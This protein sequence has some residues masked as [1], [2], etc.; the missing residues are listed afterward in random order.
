VKTTKVE[1]VPEITSLQLVPSLSQVWEVTHEDGTR[2]VVI[3]GVAAEDAVIT[4]ARLREL[5]LAQIG[6]V[7]AEVVADNLLD[8]Y[9]TA[10]IREVWPQGRQRPDEHYQRVADEYRAA[11][12][13]RDPPVEAIRERWEVGRA[14]ASRYVAEA[15]QRGYLDYPSRVGVA[16]I[17]SA[18]SPVKKK[19]APKKARQRTKKGK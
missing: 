14:M 18:K 3:D 8:A 2:E 5:P 12:A 1:G 19:A 15:R 17:G 11:L 16:G 7:A 13:R 9:A 4:S 10:A 6:A